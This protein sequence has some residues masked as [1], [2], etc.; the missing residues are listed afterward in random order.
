MYVFQQRSK[1][2][3]S[4]IFLKVIHL[5]ACHYN[6]QEHVR[7]WRRKSWKYYLVDEHFGLNDIKYLFVVVVEY[8]NFHD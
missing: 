8:N 6:L 3:K 5:V 1:P 7:E 4:M 2:D